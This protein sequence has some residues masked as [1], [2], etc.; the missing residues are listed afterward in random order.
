MLT[1]RHMRAQLSRVLV[2]NDANVSR[3]KFCSTGSCGG[4]NSRFYE[5]LEN[6]PFKWQFPVAPVT[7]VLN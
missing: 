4:S 3:N 5:K 1:G 2:P 6:L 7:T